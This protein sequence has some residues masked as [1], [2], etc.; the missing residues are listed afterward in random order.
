MR[1]SLNVTDIV[2]KLY[3]DLKEYISNKIDVGNSEIDLDGLVMYIIECTIEAANALKPG[4]VYPELSLEE[5]EQYGLYSEVIENIAIN[6]ENDEIIYADKQGNI[7]DNF[8]YMLPYDNYDSF[9]PIIEFIFINIPANYDKDLD[10]RLVNNKYLLK[11]DENYNKWCIGN[12]LLD[13][14]TTI[15]VHSLQSLKHLYIMYID[16]IPNS[17]LIKFKTFV[18]NVIHSSR[19]LGSIVNLHT[20][21]SSSEYT[22]EEMFILNNLSKYI[23]KEVINGFNGWVSNY[24]IKIKVT[25]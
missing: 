19:T 1:N 7:L 9:R 16:V 20:Y 14:D 17:N 11:L 13:I 15:K 3:S 22:K 6:I 24:L 23:T 25:Q 8:L 18:E 10:L 2:N 5:C 4:L 12:S 21:Y